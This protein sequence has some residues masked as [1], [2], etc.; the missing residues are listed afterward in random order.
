MI[1][2]PALPEPG[3]QPRRVRRVV[4]RPVANVPTP[5]SEPQ[6]PRL[7]RP[8]ATCPRCGAR[9]AMRVTEAMVEAL[10]GHPADE[11]VGTYQCQRRGCGAIYDLTASAYLHAS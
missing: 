6:E 7:L 9:P 8:A 1:A 10:A 11:R 5:V 3:L 2:M 4:R